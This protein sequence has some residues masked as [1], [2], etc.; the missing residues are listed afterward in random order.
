MHILFDITIHKR[1]IS[2][3]SMNQYTWNSVVSALH[4]HATGI[5]STEKLSESMTARINKTSITQTKFYRSM[6]KYA[7]IGQLDALFKA[8]QLILF[9]YFGDFN[10]IYLSDFTLR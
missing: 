8:L 2:L 4:R 10:V 6:I 5:L 9:E 1:K 7:E 3:K